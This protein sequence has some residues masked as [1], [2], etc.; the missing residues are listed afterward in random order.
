ML[1]HRQTH[2][3]DH[4]GGN[5]LDGSSNATQP[6]RVFLVV[7]FSRKQ[8]EHRARKSEKRRLVI[9]LFG[10]SGRTTTQ[11]VS[12]SRGIESHISRCFQSDNQPMHC[13]FGKLERT[14]QFR[15]S[16]PT[17]PSPSA[18]RIRSA[19]ISDFTGLLF[20][21]ASRLAFDF[22]VLPLLS[23]F[24][25]GRLNPFPRRTGKHFGIRVI[26]VFWTESSQIWLNRVPSANC[27]QQQ[28]QISKPRHTAHLQP[29]LRYNSRA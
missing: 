23:R 22:I 4:V 20:F 27:Y 3:R 25:L 2:G 9:Q 21:W 11:A 29:Y 24:H 16:Q 5:I 8:L 15:D 1:K 19:L 17:T 26:I 28:P 6:P 13:A 10:Q 12:C 14:A 7:T 18:S